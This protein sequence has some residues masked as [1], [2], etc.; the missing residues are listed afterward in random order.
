VT[1]TERCTSL[2]AVA[3]IFRLVCTASAL[4]GASKS[5]AA[6]TLRD[7]EVALL[8]DAGGLE[9]VNAAAHGLDLVTVSI[10]RS[11]ATTAAQDTTVMAFAGALPLVWV[12][13]DFSAEARDWARER[14]PMTLLVD[15]DGPLPD[16]ER[17]RIARFLALLGRH[18]E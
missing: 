13:S 18:T 9:A 5:W 16:A 11:E 6:E 17:G 12:G 1:V 10:L 4:A 8:V 3:A 14:R 2:S 7:G 15:T